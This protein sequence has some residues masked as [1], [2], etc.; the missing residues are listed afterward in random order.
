MAYRAIRSYGSFIDTEGLIRIFWF[1]DD[2]FGD[3][4]A[5]SDILRAVVDKQKSDDR[6]ERKD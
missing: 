6:S 2:D 3:M 5:I 1:C 4:S